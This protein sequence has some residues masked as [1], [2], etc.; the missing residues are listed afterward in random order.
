MT[1][2]HRISLASV[3]A[4]GVL[5]EYDHFIKFSE[6][7]DFIIIYGPNGI[8]KTKFL[9]MID[10]SSKLQTSR[11][12]KMPFTALTLEYSNGLSLTFE[13][14]SEEGNGDSDKITSL[15][16]TLLAPM[17]SPVVWKVSSVELSDFESFID[18]RT[19]WVKVANNVWRD[20]TDGEL[21]S[22][23]E[24]E[25]RYGSRLAR[26]RRSAQ[27]GPPDEIQKFVEGLNTHL[28]ETQ[29]L[30]IEEYL[31]RTSRASGRMRPPQ[32]T[33]VEYANQMK[34]LLSSALAENS[35][36]T[37]QLDRTFPNRVLTR[38]T[39]PSLSEEEIRAKYESQNRFRSRLAQIAL[40]G[41]EPELS[42]PERKLDSFEISLLEL[43][44][45]DA[46]EKLRTFEG[47]LSKI[48]LLEE[49]INSRLLGK[50]LHVNA[51]DGLAV[52][53]GGDGRSI[54]LDSLSSGEQHEIILMHG[55]LFNVESGSLVMID[56]PEISLHVSWQIK[57]IDDV[58]RIAELSGFQFIV[59]THSPQIINTWWSH[60]TQ[61]GPV[62][63]DF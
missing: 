24:L 22:L 33:I 6:D 8:G 62:E 61:L 25:M 36:I 21:V 14:T 47:L 12:I 50:S 29:R 44:L 10:A 30:R 59:A 38:E 57:F 46:D 31:D 35:R 45:R 3:R 17:A 53:H 48:Q 41:L 55:L 23:E 37:Q 9:E 51:H 13:R 15:E 43:Y 18:S 60:A 28:I 27:P 4:T 56:E 54:D 20:P 7:Q 26:S 1:D 58:R 49:I 32:T 40:I 11:L 34:D 16:V 5:Y 19:H 42:L 63:A 52:R 2:E 39:H